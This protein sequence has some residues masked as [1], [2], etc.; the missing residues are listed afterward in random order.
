M[1]TAIIGSRTLQIENLGQYFPRE[2]TEIISGG[3]KGIDMCAKTYA[4]KNQIKFTEYLPEYSRY[5]RSAP[6]KRNLHII[7]HADL[8]LAFWTAGHAVRHMLLN[9]ANGKTSRFRYIY[10]PKKD[11]ILYCTFTRRKSTVCAA[12]YLAGN[13]CMGDKQADTKRS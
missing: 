10:F 1:K 9:N 3:A 13:C 11:E 5:G 12:F 4:E 6:L 2:T 8:I 7:A